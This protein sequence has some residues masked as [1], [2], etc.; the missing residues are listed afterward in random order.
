MTTI[1]IPDGP[2]FPSLGPAVWDWMRLN[3]V[4]GPG[5]LRGQE[6][7]EEAEFQALL[8]MA[9][10]VY[11]QG[12]RLAGRRRFKRVAWSLRKGLAKTEK[13]A[14]IAAAEL[15]P[16]APVRFDRWEKKVPAG[17][18][19]TDPYIPMIAYTEDQTE[20]LAYGALKVIL[21]LSKVANDFDIG[22]KRIMR[23]G[24]DGKAEAIATAPDAADGARTTFQ[25]M[26]ETHRLVLPRHVEAAQVMLQN[27][28]KRPM[29]DPWTLETT[30][31]FTPGE[32]SVAEATMDYARMVERGEV[33]DSSLCFF[34]RQ[35]GD[36][37]D[38]T[39]YDGMLAA[40]TEAS[41]AEAAEWS[42]LEGI[43]NLGMDPKVDKTYWERVWLNRPR[44]AAEQSFDIDQ[45]DRLTRR[46][47]EVESK[48]QVTLGFD[49]SKFRDATGIIATVVSTGFQFVPTFL[50]EDGVTF[51]VWERP[52]EIGAWEVPTDE[53]DAAIA[54]CF[55]RFQVVR[56][57]ADP[58]YWEDS[59][60]RWIGTYGKDHVHDW[61]TNRDRQMALALRG[62]QHALAQG[63]ATND[64]H[65]R[66]RAHMGNARRRVTKVH[67][68]EGNMLPTLRKE[69]K[70][71]PMKIDLAVC[72]VLSWE[73][74]GDAIAAGAL[75][76][77]KSGRL[78]A[79]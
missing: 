13:A 73:A 17:R 57:Y 9:Y 77:K 66:F 34:H 1:L 25:H 4:Y 16:D 51:A 47:V 8:Y 26:D 49:G 36:D 20:E 75:K 15:H 74:R 38:L 7:K 28:M 63:E 44:Q 58:P 27:T 3:L 52:E 33:K 50:G 70:D 72:A 76:P 68:D 29:A 39:T 35:A 31:S 41:G 56:L 67:D 60:N 65:P 30:T 11:P 6:L 45:W 23:I 61:W 37:H 79:F 21:E 2:A 5:D 62:F 43:V 54:E 53:V 24:G 48:E 42:D 12:H 32:G 71:S 78:V 55:L 64:G 14:W 59:V 40:V 10:E 18:G 22:L 19:V 69:R 46:G